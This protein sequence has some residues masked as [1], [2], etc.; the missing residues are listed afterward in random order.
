MNHQNT[1]ADP[2]RGANEGLGDS[3]ALSAGLSLSDPLPFL[4]LSCSHSLSLFLSL[5]DYDL[6][7]S[8]ITNMIIMI[9]LKEQET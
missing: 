2:G 3:A 8:S 6:Y 4:P 5:Y 9:I 7:I 1:V